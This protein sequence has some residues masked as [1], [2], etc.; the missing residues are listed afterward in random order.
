MF[1]EPLTSWDTPLL[2][3]IKEEKRKLIERQTYRLKF[4]GENQHV[5]A[6]AYELTLEQGLGF[7]IVQLTNNPETRSEVMTFLKE[8]YQYV[9][10]PEN[11]SEGESFINYENNKSVLVTDDK[12]LGLS[13]IYIPY[14]H[15]Q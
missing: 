11:V 7:P 4:A 9:H 13:V 3:I 14:D 15:G 6:V 12:I 1:N 2:S 5:R 8:R 10:D